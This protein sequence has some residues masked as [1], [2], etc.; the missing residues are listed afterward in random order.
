MNKDLKVAI[1]KLDSDDFEKYYNQQLSQYSCT[2]F[3]FSALLKKNTNNRKMNFSL[4]KILSLNLKEFDIVIVFEILKIIPIIRLKMKPKAKLILWNWN[5]KTKEIA[6]KEKLV[7]PFCETWTF[8]SNDAK[9]FGWRLNNQFYMPIN[10]PTRQA[11][12]KKKAFC[13]CLDKGRYLAIKSIRKLLMKNNVDCDF[14][15]VK[16]GSSTYA[17]QDL[18]WVKE[19]GISYKETL[20]HVFESDILIDFVKPRQSGLTVRT[21]E[22]LFYK[23][24][25]ITNNLDI[26]KYPFYNENNILI[27]NNLNEDVLKEFLHS[28]YVEINK[29]YLVPYTYNT[30]I[31]NFLK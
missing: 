21:M 26:A 28:D 3:P 25:I 23:K 29:E 7:S 15:V 27:S 9:E 4:R 12:L 6:R 31:S 5:K 2:V 16:D 19:K 18:N 24:K 8:D 1:F 22:A 11:N 17:A 13:A 14:T 30:W 10:V 20:Q